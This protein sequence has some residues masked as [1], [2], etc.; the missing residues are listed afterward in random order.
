MR[1]DNSMSDEAVLMDRTKFASAADYAYATLRRA[2]IEGRFAPG[3]RMREIEL[4]EHLGI[5]RTPTR[6]A[7][8]RLD[9]D[10]VDELYEM[11]AALEGTAAAMAAKHASP[12]DLATLERLIAEGEKL[13]RKPFNLY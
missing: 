7:L 8:T 11:R 13:D 5:S 2:I 6:Q 9:M 3:R 4:A 1:S 10:A 12:R